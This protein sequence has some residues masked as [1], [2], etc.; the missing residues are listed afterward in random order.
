[1]EV[2]DDRILL[3]RFISEQ[4]GAFVMWNS[5][6]QRVTLAFVRP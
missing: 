1:M 6:L 4:L 5:A 3:V 2:K